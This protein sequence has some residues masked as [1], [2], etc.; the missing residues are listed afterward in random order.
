MASVG[1]IAAVATLTVAVAV[2]FAVGAH[3]N[4][5]SRKPRTTWAFPSVAPAALEDGCAAWNESVASC[6]AAET[7]P[8]GEAEW[9]QGG[10]AQIRW[11]E[12]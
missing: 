12:R 2:T 10:P 4:L 5:P 1:R 9:P 3:H 6:L 8:A 11:P 7:A